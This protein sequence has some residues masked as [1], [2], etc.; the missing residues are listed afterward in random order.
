MRRFTL[1]LLVLAACSH[2]FTLVDKPP[3]DGGIDAPPGAVEFV[4]GDFGTERD[5]DAGSAGH[6]FG[7]FTA[8]SPACSATGFCVHGGLHP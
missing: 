4:S 6:V 8:A 1:S 7:G 2:D 3:A 5:F